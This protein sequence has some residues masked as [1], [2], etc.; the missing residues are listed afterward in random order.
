MITELAESLA[1]ALDP[2]TFAR[3]TGI[4]PDLWQR[5]V[6]ISDARRL[7]ILAGRQ[8]GKSTVT[9]LLAL[10]SAL[11]EPGSL[12]LIFAPAL[13][14]SSE[15]FLKIRQAH[16]KIAYPPCGLERETA[17]ELVFSHGSRIVCNPGT[18]KSTRGF[19]SVSTLIID[20]ASR[21]D[22]ALFPS[23]AP[24]VTL[25][26]RIVL[27][28][29]PFGA[30]GTFHELWSDGDAEW[31]RLKVRAADVPRRWPAEEL[32]RQ[33]A[34]LGDWWYSQEFDVS[35]VESSDQVFSYEL[36]QSCVSPLVQP[37][38]AAGGESEDPWVRST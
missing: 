34:A 12:V 10:R 31:Q 22:P 33:R 11:Y 14:Q 2:L 26:G 4:E 38:F 30:R 20:E 9:G 25:D 32:V 36:I 37:L 15:F 35:F 19:S 7:L 3:A 17:T 24:M 6:L 27:L 21:I 1:M 23:V 13:R 5:Q 28:T 18:E 29:T 8:V 16:A